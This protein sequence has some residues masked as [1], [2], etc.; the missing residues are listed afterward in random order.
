MRN[1]GRHGGSGA[2][3]KRQHDERPSPMNGDRDAAKAAPWKQCVK[4]PTGSGK[5]SKA[6][7]QLH[8]HGVG[9]LD[10]SLMPE[11]GIRGYT[12]VAF[13]SLVVKGCA[14]SVALFSSSFV[15]GKEREEWRKHLEV[16]RSVNC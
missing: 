7:V 3:G 6:N 2:Q 1:C 9:F 14:A 10:K 4:L 5:G 13:V 11:Q 15:R 8:L 12:S 16:E